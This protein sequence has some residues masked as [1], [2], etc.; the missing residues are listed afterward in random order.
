MSPQMRF[1][2]TNSH[3]FNKVE[4]VKKD[5][6]KTLQFAANEYYLGRK[7]SIYDKLQR[8][9][10]DYY[11][12]EHTKKVYGIPFNDNLTIEQLNKIEDSIWETVPVNIDIYNKPYP[13]YES[14]EYIAVT[15]LFRLRSALLALSKILPL[16]RRAKVTLAD[17]RKLFKF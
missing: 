12:N 10:N 15:G 14:R 1:L 4:K 7:K 8:L 5:I 6:D 13:N 9:L 3:R 11:I 2:L 16:E 17:L